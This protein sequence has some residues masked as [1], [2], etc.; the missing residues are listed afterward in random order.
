MSESRKGFSFL[1]FNQLH[2]I[3]SNFIQY[4]PQDNIILIS[5]SIAVL[6]PSKPGVN[7]ERKDALDAYP[8]RADEESGQTPSGAFLFVVYLACIR[9]PPRQT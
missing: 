9:L 6:I 4:C 7:G 5:I 3:S 8:E 1:L 2:A